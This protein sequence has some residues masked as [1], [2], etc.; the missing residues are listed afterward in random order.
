MLPRPHHRGALSNG[1]LATLA[2][3]VAPSILGCGDDS[4]GPAVDGG[5]DADVRDAGQDAGAPAAGTDWPGAELPPVTVV[6]PGVRREVFLVPGVTPPAH[7]TGAETPAALNATRVIR[8]RQDL[9]PPVPARA[10]L[11][12]V[13]GFLAGGPS[14]GP[15]AA[16]LVARGAT[17]GEAIEVWTIDRRANLLEDHRGID[18]AEASGDPE[19]AT[20]YYFGRDT[21]DGEPFAG[22]AA[23]AD[24]PFMSEWGMATHVEDLRRVIALVPAEHRRA[25]VFLSG[26]SFGASVA[27]LYAAWRFEDGVSGFEELAGVI[28]VDGVLGD[29][30]IGETEYLAGGEGGGLAP[31]VGLDEIRASA[32]YSALPFFGPGALVRAAIV[33]ERALLDPGG[34]RED[35]ARDRQLAIL[36]GSTPARV[37]PMTN[38]A[39]VGF[40]FDA[41]HTPLTFA[42]F[43]LGVATG[44]PIEE[45]DNPLGSGTLARPA[46]PGATYDWI[47]AFDAD[48]PGH[49]PVATLAE[50]FTRGQSDFAEWYFPTRLTI[51]ARALAGASVPEDGW[52]AA[53]GLRA[54]DGARNDA[55]FLAIPSEFATGSSYASVPRRIAG[56][57][58]EGR[59]AAGATRDEADGFLV[60]D[61]SS[62]THADPV[63]AV[64]GADNPV[65]AAVESFL[66][67]HAAPGAVTVE[68]M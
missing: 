47:D 52:Q 23:Q 39:A 41:A 54:F 6:T 59:P 36:L 28:L 38:R 40:A 8:F 10:I 4:T 19:I 29:T 27:E 2:L 7:P 46:D 53:R 20:G 68:A 9:D 67:R 26:H 48:P 16:A 14:H 33:C 64:E 51:D 63:A 21:I 24:V 60:V 1:V 30:P 12:A 62:M 56:S 35:P 18:T 61:A 13:P 66:Y 58:G 43:S 65:P 5:P 57:V 15:L 34:V 50:T 37:P 44:G 22:F 31:S 11:V 3:A 45:Y 55:P 25:R 42:A 49:T 32:R 17:A